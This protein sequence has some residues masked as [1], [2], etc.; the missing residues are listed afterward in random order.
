MG[1]GT[2][3]RDKPRNPVIAT[4]EI[5]HAAEN[6]ATV[7]ERKEMYDLPLPLGPVRHKKGLRLMDSPFWN[8]NG[9]ERR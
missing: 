1:P 2:S 8:A 9:E 6:H 3:R 4:T 5:V 7:K